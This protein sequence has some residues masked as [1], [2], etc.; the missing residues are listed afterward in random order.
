MHLATFPP[1]PTFRSVLAAAGEEL[2]IPSPGASGTPKTR[3]W[4]LP[5]RSL[6]VRP[7]DYRL[8]DGCATGDPRPRPSRCRARPPASR[9]PVLFEDRQISE[10]RQLAVQFPSQDILATWHEVEDI[11]GKEIEPLFELA[12]STRCVVS[13][14]GRAATVCA[15]VSCSRARIAPDRDA[16]SQLL[17]SKGG[18]RLRLTAFRCDNPAMRE[19]GAQ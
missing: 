9:A 1:T 10:R 14:T 5:S 6:A 8:G 12:H 19:H 7:R 13:I 18:P 2:M 3:S 16:H 11:V 17:M 15:R 4:P